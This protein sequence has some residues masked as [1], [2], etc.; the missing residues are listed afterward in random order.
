MRTPLTGAATF[1]TAGLLVWSLVTAAV[2]AVVDE[3]D[4][5]WQRTTAAPA[6]ANVITYAAAPAASGDN[7]GNS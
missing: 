7:N 4:S 6:T 2:F 5:G 3:S 1:V